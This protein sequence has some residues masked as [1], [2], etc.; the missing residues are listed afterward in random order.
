MKEVSISSSTRLLFTLIAWSVKESLCNT[1]ILNL[2]LLYCLPC[3][4]LHALRLCKQ[5]FQ[6]HFS[7]IFSL[8][9]KARY[10]KASGIYGWLMTCE[11]RPSCLLTSKNTGNKWRETTASKSNQSSPSLVLSVLCFW[12]E[13]PRNQQTLNRDV[14]LR[15]GMNDSTCLFLK[16]QL[17]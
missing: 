3:F 15:E 7:K 4:N 14:H 5:Y 16:I 2:S 1:Y 13:E 9:I 11:K 8:L 17:K 12:W 6:V 10:T